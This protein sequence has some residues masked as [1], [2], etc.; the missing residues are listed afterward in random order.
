MQVERVADGAHERQHAQSFSARPFLHH[1]PANHFERE[2]VI[3]AQ[4]KHKRRL[5]RRAEERK[6]RGRGRLAAK[7]NKSLT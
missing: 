2:R 7:S 5:L 1:A 3:A 4:A 6:Q